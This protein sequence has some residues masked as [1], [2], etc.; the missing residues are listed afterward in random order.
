MYTGLSSG[1]WSLCSMVVTDVSAEH[2]VTSH[3]VR[4][5]VC[6]LQY[7]K[8]HKIVI[9]FL[10]FG[11]FNILGRN[12]VSLVTSQTFREILVPSKR[13]TALNDTASHAGET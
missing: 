10:F 9:H 6:P 8:S 3:D 2:C 11:R 7:Q 12:T 1:S 5:D 13:R 4:V